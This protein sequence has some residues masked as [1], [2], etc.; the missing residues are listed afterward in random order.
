MTSIADLLKQQ[1]K[2]K[3]EKA[4][5]LEQ[6]RKAEEANVDVDHVQKQIK[7]LIESTN[8]VI[9]SKSYCPY[10]RQA[11]MML[12][13][14]LSDMKVA[15]DDDNDSD[16]NAYYKVIE[17]DDGQHLGWQTQVAEIAKSYITKDNCDDDDTDDA[18]SNNCQYN[19]TRSVPQIFIN[20]QYIG[21]ADD[22]TDLY[23]SGKLITMLTT[24]TNNKQQT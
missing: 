2:K 11:K 22:L 24:T 8:I 10:C 3:Q 12:Q 17:M 20:Q 14:I 13:S 23:T 15:D 7:D 16:N 1:S 9:Y 21:G 6:E 4:T 19:N 5:L 18:N